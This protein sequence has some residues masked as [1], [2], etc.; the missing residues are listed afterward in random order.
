MYDRRDSF[1]RGEIIGKVKEKSMVNGKRFH[2]SEIEVFVFH[3]RILY[4]F[5]I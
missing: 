5:V 1:T 2:R 4:F 3:S